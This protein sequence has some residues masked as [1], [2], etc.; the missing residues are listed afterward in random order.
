M[1]YALIL[2]LCSL[3]LAMN[4]ARTQAEGVLDNVTLAFLGARAG[5]CAITFDDGPGAHTARLLRILRER[6]IEAT[7]FVL[8][9]RVPRYPKTMKR[10]IL[11][12]H[13]LGNH[14]YS[15]TNLRH[16][17]PEMQREEILRA[18]E[19]LAELGVTPRFFRP[20]YGRYDSSTLMI[21]QQENMR[22]A[23]WSVDSRD[24][25]R[26]SKAMAALPSELRSPPS[27]VF[28]FHDIHS[29][30]V[31]AMPAILDTLTSAGCRFVTLSEYLDPTAPITVEK[32]MPLPQ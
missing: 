7:F 27:G 13:E 3:L 23:F 10:M 28:L 22:V 29:K 18:N 12:G 31:D 30:T 11:D 25:Q 15:H 4:P 14:T 19:V 2:L 6:R 9:S 32:A 20:P 8:G 24:W 5:T 16:L 1:H 21:T 26:S 17:A